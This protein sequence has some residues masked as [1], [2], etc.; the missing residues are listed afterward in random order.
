MLAL[1]RVSFF[2]RE[3]RRSFGVL[4]AADLA[5]PPQGLV[6][7]LGPSGAG[8]STLLFLLAG[9]LKPTRGRVV[10]RPA[11]QRFAFV[12]QDSGLVDGLSALD[13]ACL[14]LAMAG[15]RRN[16]R[17]LQGRALLEELGIGELCDRRA[18]DLS[19]GEKSRVAL[20][21]ALLVEEATI[22]ADEPTGALDSANAAAVMAHLKKAA[23]NRLVICVTHNET[24]ANA[25]ADAIAAVS[26]GKLFWQKRPTGAAAAEAPPKAT[27]NGLLSFRDAL[28]ANA[29]LLSGK[30]GRIVL[31]AGSIGFAFAALELAF[32]LGLN[33]RR[34]ASDMTADYYAPTVL[35][36]AETAKTYQS[37]GLALSRQ[38]E[39]SAAKKAWLQAQ[40][41][42]SFYPSLGFF[43]PYG[44][45]CEI[46][47]RK[48]S[49]SL[50]PSFVPG[51]LASGRPPL[52]ATEAVA[53]SSLCSAIGKTA[54]AALGCSFVLPVSQT[55]AVIAGRDTT[56]TGLF[57]RNWHFTIVGVA[58]EEETLNY[59]AVY[60][61]YP[62]VFESLAACEVEET[63][64][65][66]AGEML[67]KEEYLNDDVR[68]HEA[69]AVSA[70][71]EQ[72]YEQCRAASDMRL[73]VYSRAFGGRTALEEVFAAVA[74]LA[75]VFLGISALVAFFLELV[76]F[77]AIG[78]E[79]RRD[80]A[81]ALA[82]AAR[83]KSFGRFCQGSANV[84]FAA[85][86]GFRLLFAG[87]L[88]WSGRLVLQ[89]LGYATSLLGFS[90]PLA[91]LMITAMYVCAA[92]AAFIPLSSLRKK[93]LARALRPER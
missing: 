39:P 48:A 24:M 18:A 30:K 74:R 58:R 33:V 78:L 50:E 8:K 72:L 25:Y 22:L 20:A 93:G 73:E 60:Y 29:G 84:F 85:A 1:N 59:P 21:R 90:L 11:R 63:T 88:R 19:G 69:V 86:L 56:V 67:T 6:C 5:F 2:Y 17:C 62:L 3:G 9:F 13:N 77:A 36:I 71:A 46:A 81:L 37:A 23:E 70:A 10:R 43:L 49:I 65:I 75:G 87:L 7:V 55:P 80:Y 45:D 53:N 12:L 82:F 35:R 27:P 4:E 41:P 47:G 83:R 40:A 61:D 34:G 66:T 92:I 28:H 26:E 52:L 79:C 51:T 89:Q 32:G 14:G 42:V 76:C 64:G 15:V 91:G 31:A 44:A 68:C 38:E 57:V 54:T 16:D